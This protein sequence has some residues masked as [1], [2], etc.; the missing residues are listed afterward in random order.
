MAKVPL[1]TM[2]VSKIAVHQAVLFGIGLVCSVLVITAFG[3]NI[4]YSLNALIG[5]NALVGSAEPVGPIGVFTRDTEITLKAADPVTSFTLSGQATLFKDDSLIRVTM[6]DSNNN[7]YLVYETSDLIADSRNVKADDVCEETCA[8]GGDGSVIPT[9]LVIHLTDADIS[10]TNYTGM[11]VKHL[12]SATEKTKQKSKGQQI[13]ENKLTQTVAQL[14]K[15]LKEKNLHWIAGK[16]SVAR[17]TYAQKK[18]LFPNSDDAAVKDLPNLQ[19]FEYYVGGVFEVAQND[20][21]AIVASASATTGAIPVVIADSSAASHIVAVASSPD[22]T[23]INSWDWRN[24]NGENWVTPAKNQGAC[25]SCW[26]FA[27][28]GAFE[29]VA[30]LYFNQHINLDLSEQDLISC[31]WPSGCNSGSSYAALLY[32]TDTGAVSESCLPYQGVDASGCIYGRCGYLAV[33]C[34]AKCSDWQTKTIKNSGS[35][36]FGDYREETIKNGVMRYGPLA[37]NITYWNHAMA[38]IGFGVIKVGDNIYN[39]GIYISPV[40][41]QTGDSMIGQ[42]YWIF[43]NSWGTGWGESGFAKL[44]GTIPIYGASVNTPIA[45]TNADYGINCT[46]KDSDGYCNWGIGKAKPANCPTSCAGNSIEDCDDSNGAIKKCI[47]DT[48]TDVTPPT[49]AISI[50]LGA[51]STATT[52]VTVYL[53]IFD[54]GSGMNAGA[55]MQFSNDNVSWSIPEAFT[56]TKAWT[57]TSGA[58]IKTVYAKVADAAGNWSNIMG[59]T[60]MLQSS[61]DASYWTCSDA[62]ETA[63]NFV[64]SSLVDPTSFKKYN[65]DIAK[66]K[67]FDTFT[68]SK[69]QCVKGSSNLGYAD[70][71]MVDVC[72]GTA[73]TPTT[74]ASCK[75]TDKN[76][77]LQEAFLLDSANFSAAA[78]K[79]WM[80]TGPTTKSMFSNW[81]YKCPNGCSNGACIKTP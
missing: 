56:P 48:T 62:A 52:A 36:G 79:F 42:T 26:A 11:A 71:C 23:V 43:K 57:L 59:G 44:S 6:I 2:A 20:V 76:C 18:S 7:E 38:L 49:G 72:S 69:A 55:K 3:W 58:G 29:A 73:C 53:S 22:T 32:F 10:I 15:R 25:G 45:I 63:N 68:K 4:G 16:T 33:P 75:T 19:G 40:T 24:A 50:N 61:S 12:L 70:Y 9:K 77:R 39:G 21:P 78:T 81:Q 30:N 37:M 8:L 66:V 41:I 35:S 1:R 5:S 64:L 60:I 13:K 65:G 31:Y 14:N 17:M 47:L 67:Y 54:A 27:A 28:T 51:T 34:S 74:V 80:Q 46:D